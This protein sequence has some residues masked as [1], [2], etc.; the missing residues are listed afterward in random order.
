MRFALSLLLATSISPFTWQTYADTICSRLGVTPTPRVLII[1]YVSDESPFAW[2]APHRNDVILI[3]G[4]LRINANQEV[5]EYVLTHEVCHLKYRHQNGGL[6]K[7]EM[8][9]E[10]EEC[11]K[12]YLGRSYASYRHEF[13]R[14]RR[15]WAGRTDS[16]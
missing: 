6:T 1:V 11:V 13:G 9:S 5:M 2:I 8:E 12:H 15:K 4:W 3:T 14:L 10:A 7:E 16:W